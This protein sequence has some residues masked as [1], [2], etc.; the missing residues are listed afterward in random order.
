MQR[1]EGKFK[2]LSEI[3]NEELHNVSSFFEKVT[4]KKP[5]G[6]GV[7]FSEN[8]IQRVYWDPVQEKLVFNLVSYQIK[9]ADTSIF[10]KLKRHLSHND[11]TEMHMR[12]RRELAI[13]FFISQYNYKH[14]LDGQLRSDMDGLEI[15][16]HDHLLSEIAELFATVY[17]SK[18][19]TRYDI[20]EEEQKFFR[21][22]EEKTNFEKQSFIDFYKSNCTDGWLSPESL[23]RLFSKAVINKAIEAGKD[24][25]WIITEFFNKG[26]E[27]F[28]EEIAKESKR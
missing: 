27:A 11:I 23:A 13:S 20:Q 22:I 14:A 25:K 4:G 2:E 15:L 7:D 9:P 10:A 19:K 1:V 8:G 21:K 3:L 12:M 6:V 28:L 26:P 5:Q 18:D 17:V 16:L 24:Y